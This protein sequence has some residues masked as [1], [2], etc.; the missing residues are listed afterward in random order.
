M[1]RLRFE[2]CNFSIVFCSNLA[3]NDIFEGDVKLF[4]RKSWHST[5]ISEI[6]QD[7]D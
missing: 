5:E 1:T 3:Q 2:N 6:L 7:F 4:D